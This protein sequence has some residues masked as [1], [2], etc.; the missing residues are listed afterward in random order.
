MRLSS[1]FSAAALS[2]AICAPAG[3]TVFS[4]ST[5]LSGSAESPVNGSTATGLADVSFDD[6]AGNVTVVV[7]FDGLSALAS[8]A[9]IHCCVLPTAV[10][11]TTGVAL[12]FAGFPNL[13]SDVYVATLSTFS[14]GATFASVLVGAQAGKAYVNIHDA[15]F[16][17][18]EVRGFLAAVPEPE[19]Y[20]LML[21]GLG[22]LAWV[23]KR[24][25]Q[26]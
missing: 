10:P 6:V 7:A 23:A 5:T 20:A 9:H 13:T 11:S 26:A 17:G 2:L 16:P 1:L 18:G 15:N 8:A 24:R 3:A 21:A 12:G 4:F 14:G 22:A 19:T 25:Q